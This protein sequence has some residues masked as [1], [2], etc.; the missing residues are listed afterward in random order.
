MGVWGVWGIA[1]V[2]NHLL[3]QLWP[4]FSPLSFLLFFFTLFY[5]YSFLFLIHHLPPSL[6]SPIS[7]FLAPLSLLSSFPFPPTRSSSLSSFF[8]LLSPS[9]LTSGLIAYQAT[10][11]VAMGAYAFEVGFKH[12]LS[13][14]RVH[15]LRSFC[16]VTTKLSSLG[17]LCIVFSLTRLPNRISLI[18]WAPWLYFGGFG[19]MQKH[20]Y[21]R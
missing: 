13:T 14:H 15:F 7:Y 3:Q 4:L 21:R 6:L 5:R 17:F 1:T 2:T 11:S 9:P 18:Y 16:S 19:R 20:R 10:D 8:S 12:Q